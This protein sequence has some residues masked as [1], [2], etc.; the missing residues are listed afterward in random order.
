LV[1]VATH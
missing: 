1:V